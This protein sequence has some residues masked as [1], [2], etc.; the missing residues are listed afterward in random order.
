MLI[1]KISPAAGPCSSSMLFCDWTLLSALHHF[2]SSGVWA[3]TFS[4]AFLKVSEGFLFVCTEIFL[5]TAKN[6]FSRKVLFCLY[7]KAKKAS[8]I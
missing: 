2:Q 3:K 8:A 5:A 1:C 4:A 7:L 6:Y